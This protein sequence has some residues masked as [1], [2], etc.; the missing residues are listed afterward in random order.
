VVASFADNL[1]TGLQGLAGC[2]Q[3]QELNISSNLVTEVS[4]VC[5]SAAVC[6]TTAVSA[7]W[8]A[9][10]YLF[11]LRQEERSPSVVLTFSFCLLCECCSPQLGE[12]SKMS[13]LR[14]LDASCNCI[15]SLLPLA[16]LTGLSQLSVEGNQLASLAGLTSM[17]G[18][19]ELYAA[20]N[21]VTDIKVGW[22]MNLV[23][24][25]AVISTVVLTE[26]CWKQC[27]NAA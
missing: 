21:A 1:L 17:T 20:H 27:C 19:L 7:K 10:H 24:V 12:L 18:L 2:G 11:A 15:S 22:L 6:H 9:M 5:P 8:L 23:V 25:R 3:L 26:G 4:A 13:S 16:A 14:Q